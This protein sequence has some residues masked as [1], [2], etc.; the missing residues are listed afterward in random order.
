MALRIFGN[1]TAKPLKSSYDSQVSKKALLFLEIR[2]L[3]HLDL[4]NSRF[5]KLPNLRLRLFLI[6]QFRLRTLKE[7]GR[8]VVKHLLN[9]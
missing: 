6:F 1:K 5:P 8:V 4:N 2:K 3:K 9:F 7:S